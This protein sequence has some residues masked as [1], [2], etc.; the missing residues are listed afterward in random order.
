MDHHLIER[1]GA[2][3]S[4]KSQEPPELTQQLENRAVTKG[5]YWQI[6]LKFRVY[7]VSGS[8]AGTHNWPDFTSQVT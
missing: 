8:E 3:A 1:R 5:T 6:G 4:E 2:G 7:S